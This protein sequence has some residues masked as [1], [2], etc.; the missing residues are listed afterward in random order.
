M[1]IIIYI[2]FLGLGDFRKYWDE[3]YITYRLRKF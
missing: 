2:S 1:Q 3:I